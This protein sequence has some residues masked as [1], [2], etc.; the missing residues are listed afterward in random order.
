MWLNPVTG[1]I[2]NQI[3]SQ[4]TANEDVAFAKVV[5]YIQTLDPNSAIAADVAE[6]VYQIL[7]SSYDVML[8]SE[9]FKEI[10]LNQTDGAYK[11]IVRAD[12][13]FARTEFGLPDT[14]AITFLEN[15][16]TLYLGKFVASADLKT[17]ITD[18][19]REA[20][21]KNG[22][23][24]GNSSKELNAFMKVFGEELDASKSDVRMI[25]DTT[26]S[27]ARV[28]GQVNGMRSAGGQT[29]EI[30]GPDDALTCSICQ[31]MVGRS[32]T[33]AGA[34]DQMDQI[35]Q[36][37]PEGIDSTAPFLKGALSVGEIKGMDDAELEAAGFSVPP[38]HPS[39]R[40]RLAISTFY[41]D[42]A[43]IPYA[44]E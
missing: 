2:F 37:G 42:T 30:T 9:Q 32:F 16:D 10:I 26:V 24:I 38:Y 17:R 1:G 31:D 8:T 39:C 44:V 14:R 15:S 23:A 43:D 41:E 35:L 21:L 40:H 6:S 19:I 5:K 20:Y 34:V 33:V 25:I 13:D 3:L 22:R 12:P 29:Y 18:Y 36:A 7:K 27:R 28:F 4:F 11:A